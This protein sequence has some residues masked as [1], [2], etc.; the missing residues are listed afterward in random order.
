MTMT[1]R[2]S[3][4]ITR[5]RT[6][7]QELGFALNTNPALLMRFIAFIIGFLVIIGNRALRQRV[8]RL[9]GAGWGKIKST[10]GMGTRVSY[11]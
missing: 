7:I 9:L 10:A 4:I 2:A 5:F 8:Q 11:I 6:L 1:A 3:W